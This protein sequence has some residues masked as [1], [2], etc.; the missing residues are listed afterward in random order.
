MT[1]NVELTANIKSMAINLGFDKVGITSA[2]QPGKSKYLN[3][4]LGKNFQGKMQWLNRNREKRLDSALLF[5]GIKSVI[6][7]AQNYYTPFAHVQKKG[8]GK[9]SRYAWGQDYHRIMK[10]KLKQLLIQIKEIYPQVR[11][12]LCV[13]TAPIM[14]KLWAEKAG[15]G[16]QGKHS[17]LISKD[18]GSWLF[19]GELLIDQK[20]I[21]DM[22]ATDFC[23]SCQACIKACPTGAIT[24]PYIV[25]ATKCISYLTIEF[26][27]EP[28]PKDF[29][30]KMNGWIFGCDI[31]QDICPW[32]KFSRESSESRYYP[33]KE[34][35]NPDLKKW[36]VMDEK[37]YKKKF[38]NSP[39]SRPGFRN[40]KRNIENIYSH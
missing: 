16:W 8:I 29:Q 19:L 22:P 28:I 5:P 9:I 31:C 3:A 14:E 7:V 11:G 1:S 32:N 27:N 33:E 10:T 15:L 25:N 13:D 6:C 34:N 30:Q 40:F 12:R 37:T 20:L 21:Y 18:Y 36:A 39:I 24:A 38:K 4:W 2:Q 23:G 35:L 17:N 26:R